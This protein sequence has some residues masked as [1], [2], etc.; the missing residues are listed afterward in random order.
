MDYNYDNKNKIDII[1]KLIEEGYT[2]EQILQ[3]LKKDREKSNE[4][5][6]NKIPYSA[7]MIQ[8]NS[9]IDYS[10]VEE[11]GV[12]KIIFKLK[13]MIDKMQYELILAKLDRIP[14]VKATAEEIKNYLIKQIKENAS[15]N[16][17]YDYFIELKRKMDDKPFEFTP[18]GYNVLSNKSNKITDID[19]NYKLQK[20]TQCKDSLVFVQP[21]EKKSEIEKQA[22]EKAN[23]E[24]LKM[25][26]EQLWQERKKKVLEVAL[27]TEEDRKLFTDG[28]FI[29][30][31]LR[32]IEQSE[33][34]EERVDSI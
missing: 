18:E 16:G 7:K 22:K 10:E 30:N 4:E 5:K 29:V 9:S 20:N 14:R 3:L 28:D 19:I 1:T 34:L 23:Y 26:K 17:T 8:E 15:K 25:Q 27:R 6:M 21:V 2:K 32:I 12:D 31:N 24:I 13:Y 33:E 11:N